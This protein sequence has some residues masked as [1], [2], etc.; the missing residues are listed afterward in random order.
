MAVTKL[1][2]F[3]AALNAMGERPLADTGENIKSGRILVQ[4]YDDVVADCIAAGNWNYA[5]ETVQ[6]DAD[7]GV[8]PSFGYTEVFAK[9]SD[10]VRT[11]QIS[12]DEFFNLPLLEYYDDANFF[13]ANCT[14]IYLRYVSDDTGLGLELNLWP[15]KFRRYVELEL[16]ARTVKRITGS[17][18]TKDEVVAERDKAKLDALNTAAM[19]RP[20]PRFPPSGSWTRSRDGG[21]GVGRERGVRNKLIG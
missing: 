1:K 14:P 16:S 20:Q 15:D 8:E 21:R 18:S 2:L 4:N 12:A 7:T 3:N 10:W 9:P 19:N 5:K 13:S 6:L 17:D 11:M